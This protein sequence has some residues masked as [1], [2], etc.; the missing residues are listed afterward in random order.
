MNMLDEPQLHWENPVGVSSSQDVLHRCG[1][2]G[3][4]GHALYVCLEGA[5]DLPSGG[6]SKYGSSVMREWALDP[7][8]NSM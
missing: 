1:I 2:M 6:G 5:E 8:R 7:W 4:K 3:I